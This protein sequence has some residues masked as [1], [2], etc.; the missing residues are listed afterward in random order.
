VAV[1]RVPALGEIERINAVH[2]RLIFAEF[3]DQHA[4]MYPEHG[5]LYRPR[6]VEIIEIGCMVTEEERREALAST[7]RL[8][9]EMR[10]LMDAEGIDLWACPAAP[11]PA[12]EGIQATGDPA[13]NLPW[14]HAGMPA[15]SLPAGWAA[16]GLPLGLQ[17][18]ARFGEDEQL[19]AWAE[20]LYSLDAM[21]G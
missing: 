21:A 16:N 15:A 14:T 12:P 2:R 5:A 9:R 11:G 3:A 10:A 1:R 8:R 19:L 7:G 20:A 13:M 4:D 18:I 6:T 17:L